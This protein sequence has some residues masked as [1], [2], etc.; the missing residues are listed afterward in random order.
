MAVR[1]LFFDFE[2]FL[3]K[4]TPK[5]LFAGD[6]YKGQPSVVVTEDEVLLT[7]DKNTLVRVDPTFGVQ[8]SGQLSLSATPEQISIAGGYWRFNPMLLSCLPSTTP[9]P[10][11]TLVKSTP[12]LLQGQKQADSAEDFLMSFSDAG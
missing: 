7:G 9:T 5:A 10:I 3:G 2:N 6:S 1:D 11:P 4:L 12:A 8:L